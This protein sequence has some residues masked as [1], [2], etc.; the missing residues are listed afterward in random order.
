MYKATKS[1]TCTKIQHPSILHTPP[2]V[3]MLK[4]SSSGG[5]MFKIALWSQ[6]TKPLTLTP[7]FLKLQ[8]RLLHKSSTCINNGKSTKRLNGI[9]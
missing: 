1:Y 6:Y 8:L 4:T 5:N 2:H 7:Q 9:I 3:S